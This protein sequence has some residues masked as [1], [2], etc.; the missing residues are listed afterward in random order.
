[1]IK[2][3]PKIVLVTP[4]LEPGI[5]DLLALP[6]PFRPTGRIEENVISASYPLTS[7]L[8]HEDMKT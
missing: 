6:S 7:F 5:D 8:G 2:K 3:K 4:C 1:M